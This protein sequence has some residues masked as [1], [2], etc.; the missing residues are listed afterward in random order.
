MGFSRR[1]LHD[2]FLQS[3][4]VI[5]VA[6]TKHESAEKTLS[7]GTAFITPVQF[8]LASATS[9]I[10]RLLSKRW[11][12]TKFNI[13][14]LNRRLGKISGSDAYFLGPVS[15]TLQGRLTVWPDGYV[16]T[17]FIG[18]WIHHSVFSISLTSHHR[19]QDL[20]GLLINVFRCDSWLRFVSWDFAS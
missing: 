9:G 5:N 3:T 19:L 11:P 14:T 20:V 18:N 16:A 17:G 4:S 7:T 12:V 2:L 1:Q 13:P 15:Q 10:C 6:A 8:I